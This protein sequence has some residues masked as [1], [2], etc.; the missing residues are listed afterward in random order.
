MYARFRGTFC[1]SI[2]IMYTFRYG[3]SVAGVQLYYS[4][5]TKNISIMYVISTTGEC[6]GRAD[7]KFDLSAVMSNEEME[8]FDL[9]LLTEIVT[10]G[11]L[12]SLRI[13]T[14]VWTLPL[15]PTAIRTCLRFLH[16]GP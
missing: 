9:V 8:V 14:P 13:A 1:S 15:F 5:A 7:G 3:E 4:N 6:L 2:P 10:G 11:P 12:P 16:L